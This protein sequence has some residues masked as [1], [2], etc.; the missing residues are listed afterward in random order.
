[1][2][3]RAAGRRRLLRV[4]RGGA[5]PVGRTDPVH[6]H[7]V[8]H[9]VAIEFAFVHALLTDVHQRL[10]ETV[11]CKLRLDLFDVDITQFRE[12]E[13][14]CEQQLVVLATPAMIVPTEI[15]YDTI[16]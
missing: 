1:M 7:A 13:A 6:A 10:H 5:S 3:L 15:G 8:V 16:Q 9:D 2:P 14:G 11:M 4:G 12:A